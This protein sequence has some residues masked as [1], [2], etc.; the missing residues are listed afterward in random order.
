MNEKREDS[1]GSNSEYA[2]DPGKQPQAD[3]PKWEKSDIAEPAGGGGGFDDRGYDEYGEDYE[4]GEP[5]YVGAG[6][7]VVAAIADSILLVIIGAII[8]FVI[9]TFIPSPA[10][11]T[12]ST[13]GGT[14]VEP[15]EGTYWYDEGVLA[16]LEAEASEGYAFDRWEGDIYAVGDITAA[17]TSILMDENYEVNAIFRWEP[18]PVPGDTA[19]P[20][21]TPAPTQTPP[22]AGVTY[23][24]PSEDSPLSSISNWVLFALGLLYFPG[25]WVWRGQTPGKVLMGAYIV[26]SDGSPMGIGT[27]LL[28]Y[29]TYITIFYTPI[30]FISNFYIHGALAL[31]LI[32]ACFLIVAM[33]MKKQGIHDRIA[34]TYVIKV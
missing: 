23:G 12:A 18:T 4:E 15:G 26:K 10:L 34:G 19:T 31:A 33:S 14:I 8:V 2:R 6:R 1:P 24:E 9:G 25:F 22:P 27:A 29:V 30:V 20:T 32:V 11:R 17:E 3:P 21:A 28:R 13:A 16:K 7:R 5:E